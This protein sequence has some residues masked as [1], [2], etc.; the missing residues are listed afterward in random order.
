M[1]SNSNH[2]W[3]IGIGNG[4]WANKGSEAMLLTVAEQMRIRLGHQTSCTVFVDRKSQFDI[5]NM[6]ILTV[7]FAQ[8]KAMQIVQICCNILLGLC[9]RYTKISMLLRA[10]PELRALAK[11]DAYIDVY[12]YYLHDGN[13][14][15]GI[16]LPLLK[17]FYCSCVGTPA[18]MLPQSIGPL[19]KPVH[20][21]IIQLLVPHFSKIYVRGK[22]SRAWLQGAIGKQCKVHIAN[23]C[24]FLF[25]QK[26]VGGKDGKKEKG[27]VWGISVNTNLQ[28]KGNDYADIMAQTTTYLVQTHNARVLLIPHEHKQN[29]YDDTNLC[30]DILSRIAPQYKRSVQEKDVPNKTAIEYKKNIDSCDYII[31]A[32][33]HV[34]IAALS[35]RKPTIT[36]GWS[37]KYIE[38]MESVYMG[39]YA[40][41]GEKVRTV[42]TVI[43]CIKNV[44]ENKEKIQQKLAE[45]VSEIEDNTSVL[46]DEI[47][48]H[49]QHSSTSHE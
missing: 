22:K 37:E 9:Y 43:K 45:V 4:S 34:A 23:D 30:K 32:R 24:A 17:A 25:A 26:E 18:Y 41:D 48:W 47:A 28:K 36:L 11:Q 33:F 27:E 46:F 1:Q 3:H 38:L 5:H 35:L 42:A 20:K 15:A 49:V 2:Q 6:H 7:S 13:S 16:L 19:E 40:M 12:G 31:A 39:E 8:K 21:R 14:I 44:R 29:K 10:C